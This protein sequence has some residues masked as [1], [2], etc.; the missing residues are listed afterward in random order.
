M[1]VVYL[2]LAIIIFIFLFI[3]SQYKVFFLLCMIAAALSIIIPFLTFSKP[4]LKFKH[5]I[6]TQNTNK[7]TSHVERN[8]K[9]ILKSEITCKNSTG[10]IDIEYVPNPFFKYEGSIIL[11]KLV[12]LSKK[13]KYKTEYKMHSENIGRFYVGKIIIK[14]KS[15]M[16]LFWTEMEKELPVISIYPDVSTKI[17][18]TISPRKTTSSIG[19]YTSKMYGEGLD[20]AD[21]T[22]YS[23]GVSKK[24]IN[25]KI[26]AKK[27]VLY[28]N[29]YNKECNANILF[30]IDSSVNYGVFDLNTRNK[31]IE[32][33]VLLSNY[34]IKLKDRI[35]VMEIGIALRR[36]PFRTGRNHL[37]GIIEFLLDIN[38]NRDYG[39][40]TG[41][42]KI[43]KQ[44][45]PHNGIV[46]I[47]TSSSLDNQDMLNTIR[48]IKLNG[49]DVI[50]I[51]LDTK[52]IAMKIVD[53]EWN[54]VAQRIFNIRYENKSKFL[55]RNNIIHQ[56][57]NMEEPFYQTLKRIERIWQRR[58]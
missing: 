40:R 31:M 24:Q 28:V 6:I 27:N 22:E 52:E 19:N 57:W 30:I 53:K 45:L 54:D 36:T 9:F 13:E 33:V 44:F 58:R 41:G 56:N 18:T 23:R 14:Y 26:S 38:N 15:S 37:F 2:V 55:S 43:P 34:Y 20:F 42:I 4:N 12:S 25:W 39:F 35:S 16:G 21:V 50:V 29:R 7:K 1:S 48:W 3:I 17:K 5:L 8:E 51:T 49:L 46:Y 10:Y 47:F 32:A 11:R